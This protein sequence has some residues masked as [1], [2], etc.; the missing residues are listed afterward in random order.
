MPDDL[1][2][3]AR[4]IQRLEETGMSRRAIAEGAG[5]G[6]SQITRIMAGEARNP[7][8]RVINSLK[9]FYRETL[10]VDEPSRQQRFAKGCAPRASR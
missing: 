7:T 8:L 6:A 2:E 9:R 10:P 4:M 1:A 3:V 5:I